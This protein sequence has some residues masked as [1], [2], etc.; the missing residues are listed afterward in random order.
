MYPRAL[1]IAG[2]DSGGGAGI[3]ADLKTFHSLGVY[4]MSAVTALTAQNTRGVHG[5]HN[6]PPEF[7]ALQLRSVLDDIGA[8][9]AKT[10]MLS[11]AHLIR[12]VATVLSEFHLD[13]LVVDPVMISKHGDQLLQQDAISTL[14]SDLLPLSFIITPNTPEARI[15]ADLPI[16]DLNSM[17]EAARRI[18]RLGPKFIVIK[19]GHLPLPNATDLFFDGTHMHILEEPRIPSP[20]THGTGCTFSAAITALLARGQS[21]LSA[22]THAKKF[23]AYAI[24]HAQPLG[25]GIAPVNHLKARDEYASEDF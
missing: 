24:R 11:T 14:I 3:Q 1:T 15:L 20:H 13:R 10:G 22:V 17:K 12:T 16:H 8:D 19:G 21:P 4:G 7:L 2:S 18:H 5:I 23:T 9:A 25:H 6:V